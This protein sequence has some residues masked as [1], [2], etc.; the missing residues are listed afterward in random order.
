M[1]IPNRGDVPNWI[2]ENLPEELIGSNLFVFKVNLRVKD[3]ATGKPKVITVDMLPDLMC[4]REIVETQMEDIPAQYAFWAAV[5]SEL[6]MNV[7]VMERALKVR[8]GKAIE[9]VQKRARDENIKFTADQVK[10]VVEADEQLGKLD[11]ALAKM[12]MHTGKVYHMLEA[13]KFKAEM[14]RSLLA[15][16]R[17]EYDKT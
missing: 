1:S 9:S 10:N 8:K 14:S 12:Q 7:A 15:T 4:E 17:Q 13:L 3:K 6:R 11:E 5:Y 2:N 16:K